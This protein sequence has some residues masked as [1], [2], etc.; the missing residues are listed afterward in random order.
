MKRFILYTLL[1][2]LAQPLFATSIVVLITPDYILLGA[3][4]KRMIIDYNANTT[5]NQSVC[6]IQKAGKYCY[7]LAG[8]VASRNTSFS[9]DSIVAKYLNTPGSKE[10]AIAK[11][12]TAIKKALRKEFL[13]Q[14]QNDPASFKKAIEAK[15]HILE[16]VILS[17][18]NNAPQAQIIGF[19]LTDEKTIEVKEYAASCPGDCPVQ[20]PQFYF[21]GEYS[22]MEKYLKEKGAPADP[23]SLVEQLIINQSKAT[24]GYVS[25]PVSIVR[26][27][28]KGMEWLK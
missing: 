8:L 17:V 27:T 15:E 10:Q 4:S 18:C 19:Q 9:A 6:K 23:V 24:P 11:I 25:A 2:L 16:V 21:L 12:K 3:D 22:G 28:A 20:Q 26:Y 7:A 13:Y 5:I 14:Q 1:F